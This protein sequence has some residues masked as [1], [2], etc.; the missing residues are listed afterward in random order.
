MMKKK[1]NMY[2]DEEIHMQIK[3]IAAE[4]RMNITKWIIEAIRVK[5]EQ[6]KNLGF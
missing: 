4:K 6:E 2:L 5:L 1:L 3:K